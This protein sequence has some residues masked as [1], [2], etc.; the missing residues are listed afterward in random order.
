MISRCGKKLITV[1]VSLLIFPGCFHVS[2]SL[3]P[4]SRPLHEVQ[5]GGEGK[6]KILMLDISGVIKER[7]KRSLGMVQAGTVEWVRANLDRA[8]KDKDVRALILRINSPGGF[9]TACDIVHSELT[10]FK[11][12][13]RI[14]VIAVLMGTATSGGYYVATAADFIIA[15]PTTATGSVGVIFHEIDL[16]GLME[17]IGV[18]EEAIKTGERKDM[19]S[20]FRGLTDRERELFREIIHSHFLQFLR[21][22]REGRKGIPEESIEAVSDG[23][24][25]TAPQALRLGLIDSIGY[26]DD[27]VEKARDMAGLEEARLMI[28]LGNHGSLK[29]IYTQ[30]GSAGYEEEEGFL[31]F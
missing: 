25:L 13:T 21:V 28:Y 6:G 12:V 23:R 3:F 16:R 22:I 10:R 5:V 11:Q 7:G 26:L 18:T 17:K 24:I 1:F 19:G 30:G 14:P 9:V 2:G 20:L 27:G 4:A 31:Y 29:T 15:H 8:G